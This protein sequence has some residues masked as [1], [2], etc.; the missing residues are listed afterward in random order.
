M[1]RTY[2]NFTFWRTATS[3]FLALLVILPITGSQEPRFVY[4]TLLQ[5]RSSDGRMVVRVHDDL[6][7]NLR[8]TSVAARRL[9][10]LKHERGQPVTVFY[11]GESINK[12]L[13]EDEIALATLTV[14]S[15]NSG[16][17]MRGILGPDH[18]I[19]PVAVREKSDSGTIRHAIYKIEFKEMLDTTI[20]Q[21]TDEDE[22]MLSER[23]SSR[24]E[25]PAVVSIEVFFV[26]HESHHRHFV[27]HAYALW[28][29]C[30][31]T[32]SANLRLASTYSP[33]IQLIVSGVELSQ[34]ESYVVRREGQIHDSPTLGSFKDYAQNKKNDYGNPD[35]V[36]LM[37]REDVYTVYR[38]YFTSAGLGIA[39]VAGVCIST[40]VGLGEDEA[41]LFTGVHTF[42]HE[43]AHLLGASHDGNDPLLSMPGHP[44]SKGCP[45]DDGFLM[46]YVNKGPN[47]QEFSWCSAHQMQYVIRY[48]GPKCWKHNHIQNVVAHVYPG[49]AVTMTDFCMSLLEDKFNFT[50]KMAEILPTTCK[51]RC[52]YRRNAA[53]RYS[54]SVWSDTE[55]IFRSDDALDHMPCGTYKVCMKNVCTEQPH[56]TRPQERDDHLMARLLN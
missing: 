49:M 30:V 37:I 46:S 18:R 2:G 16:V 20:S 23:T 17:E 36:Y 3:T 21:A 22:S 31:I 41:G 39:Y 43:T 24:S 1:L 7:L 5:Q 45:W 8:K 33:K 26:L 35:I 11:D 53:D 27:H 14:T 34:D 29:V 55:T 47:H 54:T 12:D 50:F 13:Y 52:S 42:T 9:R 10:V 44:G 56:E 51:V 40:Y 28:Y 32:N 25:V 48:R 38:G 15:N 19:E 6:T 4:P